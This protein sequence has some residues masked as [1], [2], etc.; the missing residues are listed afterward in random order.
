MTTALA[1]ALASRKHT[2][3][4]MPVP[5]PVTIA[6]FPRNSMLESS[7]YTRQRCCTSLPIGSRWRFSTALSGPR[8]SSQPRGHR[9]DGGVKHVDDAVDLLLG[10]HERWRDREHVAGQG[11]DDDALLKRGQPYVS[12]CTRR[13]F[14]Q[15]LRLL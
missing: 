13:G 10:D 2:A 5:P 12:S 14:E 11:S 6:T 9:I 7:A 3:R 8:S 15:L 4:P 1:P